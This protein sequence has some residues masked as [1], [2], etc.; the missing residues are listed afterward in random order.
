MKK[1][2][3]LSIKFLCFC[4]VDIF[5]FYIDDE[6]PSD[7]AVQQTQMLVASASKFFLLEVNHSFEDEFVATNP[8]NLMQAA[9]DTLNFVRKNAKQ[10]SCLIIPP[11]LSHIL[12]LENIEN[13]LEYIISIIKQD[14]PSKKFRILNTDFLNANFNFI[15]WNADRQGALNNGVNIAADGMIRL[16]NYAIFC[17]QGSYEKTKKYFCPLYQILDNRICKKY[18]KQQ[19]LSGIL[20]QPSNK[21][22]ARPMCWLSRSD[23]EDSL[24]QGTVI[25][26]MPDGKERVFVVDQNNGIEYDKNNKNPWQQ[27]RYWYFKED[28][29]SNCLI[30]RFKDRQNVVFAADMFNIGFGKIIVLKHINPFTKKREIRLGVV[31]DTGGAFAKNLYQLD[32]FA[33]IFHNRQDFTKY[34]KNLPSRTKAYV[35]V[36][37]L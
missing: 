10:S 35:L 3:F 25:V 4:S 22:K 7:Y 29:S 6:H 33:G 12:T 14:M 8:Y 20:N 16:T 15:R 9:Q 30:E 19:I 32:F 31:A 23:F 1:F 36:H 13:T 24:M 37:R 2:I 28:K 34:I 27:K 26:K 5:C 21:G 11:H 18:S 17:V